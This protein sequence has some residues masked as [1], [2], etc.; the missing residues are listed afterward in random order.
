MRGPSQCTTTVNT[1][2]NI[3]GATTLSG[4][5]AVWV[6]PLDVVIEGMGFNISA[7]SIRQDAS[8][9]DAIITGISDLSYN[10]TLFYENDVFQTRVTVYHQDGAAS[11][12]SQGKEVFSFDRTQVDLSASYNLPLAMDMTLTLDA[13]NLTNEPV[14]NWHE[15]EGIAF[16]AFYPGATYTLGLRGSF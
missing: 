13:Y 6:Q 11:Y 10:G 16:N 7:T 9:D 3:D 12:Y 5:E 15:Y 14:G 4:F 2:N 8:D 1:R